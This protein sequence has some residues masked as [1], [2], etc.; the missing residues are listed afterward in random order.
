MFKLFIDKANH[1]YEID[2]SALPEVSQA[3]VIEYGLTQLLSDAAA[4]IATTDKVGTNRVSKTG[5]DLVKANVAA[6]ELCDQ[7]IA[8]LSAGVLRRT[9]TSSQDPIEAEATRV[10]INLVRKDKSFL[11]F[12]AQHSVKAV[13]KV[14]T[15]ELQRLVAIRVK[16]PAIIKIATRRV[17]EMEELSGLA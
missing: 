7:R 17:K 1:T 8:D 16:E 13:D 4:S 9:R 10:A 5:A 6:K 3:R 2:F 11:A 14:A 12:L 15:D